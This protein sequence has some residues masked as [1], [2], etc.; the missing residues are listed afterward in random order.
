MC[1]E[2]LKTVV[3]WKAPST[4]DRL[5][6]GR[7]YWPH[8]CHNGDRKAHIRIVVMPTRLILVQYSSTMFSRTK[9]V[10]RK[11]FYR[12][13]KDPLYVT[14]ADNGLK[15]GLSP[16]SLTAVWAR[17]PSRHRMASSAV[18]RGIGQGFG[19]SSTG[20][21]EESVENCV[22]SSKVMLLSLVRSD[23]DHPVW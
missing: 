9:A 4:S 12:A 7:G 19:S 18:W 14:K 8:S 13:Q 17:V 15:R 11:R 23:C 21:G 1:F 6:F 2:S 20:N 5:L 10:L 16:K 3:L 22:C